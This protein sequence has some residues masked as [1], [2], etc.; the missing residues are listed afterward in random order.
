MNNSAAI[1]VFTT[2]GHNTAIG[3]ED[4]KGK[5]K[6]KKET[7]ECAFVCVVKMQQNLV[8][9]FD[10]ISFTFRNAIFLLLRSGFMIFGHKFGL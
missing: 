2:P 10:A 6:M 8:K 9:W 4:Q 5:K 1:S 3:F 7:F